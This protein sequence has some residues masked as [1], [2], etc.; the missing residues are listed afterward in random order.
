[1]DEI[2]GV[3]N[4]ISNYLAVLTLYG[5]LVVVMRHA[6]PIVELNFRKSYWVLCFGWGIGVFIGNYLFFQ[7]GYMSFLP[8]ANNFLHT[9]VWIGCCLAFLYAGCYRKPLWEQFT[10]FAVFS[11]IVK[12]FER[13]IL[14]TWELDHFFMIDGSTAYIVGWSLM[15]GLYPLISKGGLGLVGRFADGVLVP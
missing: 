7:L 11:L 3:G 2:L 1:M 4:G 6:N 13:G 9:F 8:W 14:G 12:V 10:L 5:L 15:D